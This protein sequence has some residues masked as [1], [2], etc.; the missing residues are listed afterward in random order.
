MELS[1]GN[2]IEAVSLQGERPSIAWFE[3][4]SKKLPCPKTTSV[5]ISNPAVLCLTRCRGQTLANQAVSTRSSSFAD[6]NFSRAWF[7]KP[8][9]GEVEEFIVK[10]L[11][12]VQDAWADGEF[13]WNCAMRWMA[14]F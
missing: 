1:K 2:L 6:W 14:Y 3:K 12:E 10:T 11:A 4:V 8:C 5:Q 7:R 13:R 9:D